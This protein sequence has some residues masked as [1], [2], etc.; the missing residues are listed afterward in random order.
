MGPRSFSA[1]MRASKDTIKLEGPFADDNGAETALVPRLR[2]GTHL[3]AKLCFAWRGDSA[4]GRRL[5]L[6]K[7][8]YP[9]QRSTQMDIITIFFAILDGGALL[10][11]AVRYW[12]IS[13]G[14]FAAA[15][16]VIAIC[17]VSGSPVIRWIV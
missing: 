2:L 14:F 7:R 13:S 5:P 16:V 8:V 15:S 3:G 9:I 12:R 6:R 17:I 4:G 10:L 1:L 11:A